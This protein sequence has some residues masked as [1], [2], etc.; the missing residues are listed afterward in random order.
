MKEGGEAVAAPAEMN[1]SPGW[2]AIKRNFNEL[3]AALG[4]RFADTIALGRGRVK[5]FNKVAPPGAGCDDRKQGV[6]LCDMK[7]G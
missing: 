4:S 7:K 2:A 3:R 1:G 6:L 5:T